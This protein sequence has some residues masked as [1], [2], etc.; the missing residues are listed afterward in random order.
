MNIQNPIYTKVDYFGNSTKAVKE[1]HSLSPHGS[2]RVAVMK[3][4]E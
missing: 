2:L 4:T 1:K 3:Q